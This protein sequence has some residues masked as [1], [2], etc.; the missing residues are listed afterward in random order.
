[1]QV[2]TIQELVTGY[3]ASLKTCD[4]F[5]TR[6]KFLWSCINYITYVDINTVYGTYQELWNC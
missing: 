2:S 1:M 5:S 6:G 3:E 4:L